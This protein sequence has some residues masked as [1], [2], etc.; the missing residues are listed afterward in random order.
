MRDSPRGCGKVVPVLTGLSDVDRAAAQKRTIAVL[1]GALILSS[2]SV[3]SSVTVG[4]LLVSDLLGGDRWAGIGGASMTLGAAVAAVPLAR[5][6]AIHGRRPALS[7]GYALAGVGT[8]IVTIGAIAGFLPLVVCGT[9]LLGLAQASSLQ[10]RFA[11]ADLARPDDRARAIS[12]VVWSTTIGAVV[13]PN[14][15]GITSAIAESLGW[16][17][18]AGPYLASTVVLGMASFFVATFLRPDPLALAGRLGQHAGPKRSIR[19]GLRVAA[20]SPGARLAI[21]SIA[22]AHAVMVG[23]MTMTPLHLEDGGHDVEIVGIVISVH[24]AGMYALSPLSGWLTRRLGPVATILVGMGVLL[25]STGTTG[26][27]EGE[28]ATQLGVALFALGLG[29]SFTLVAG[30]ALLVEA[31]SEESRVEVQGVSDLVMSVTG[32]IAALGSGVVVD[33]V[34]YHTL[35]HMADVPAAVIGLVAAVWLVKGRRIQP[36]EAA[37]SS[38]T[39]S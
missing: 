20:A 39:P 16:R 2:A 36:E 28:E 14:T 6:A 3:T 11:A 31:V 9:L 32:G 22:I 5:Y 15:V 27:T 38:T 23:V 24:V 12:L 8:G 19:D 10:S 4:T 18:H 30:S 1:A 37:E 34:G 25:A 33:T 21:G 35:S 13:G 7:R 26:H 17:E 29:W